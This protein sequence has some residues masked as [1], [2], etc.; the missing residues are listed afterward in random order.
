[1][2][3]SKKDN[4]SLKLKIDSPKYS[5][6]NADDVN[7]IDASA[8][9]NNEEKTL[10]FFIINRSEK[11]NSELSFDLFNLDIEKIIDQQII[12]HENIYISN[13][14]DNPNAI[15]PKNTTNTFRLYIK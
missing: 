4:S 11:E 14:K 2:F 15:I 8:V 5:S 10:S 9:I 6:D 3:L 13:T 7:Y 12:N 1:M